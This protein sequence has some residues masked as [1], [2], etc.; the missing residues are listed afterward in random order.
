M[1]DPA[2]SP[3]HAVDSRALARTAA[4]AADAIRSRWTEVPRVGL[5]LGTGQGHLAEELDTVVSL[6]YAELPHFPRATALSHRGHLLCGSW[7]GVPVIAL[8]GRCHLYEGYSPAQL[9][10]PVYTLHALGVS[11]LVLSNAAGGLNPRFAA[12]DVMVIED[13]VSLFLNSSLGQAVESPEDIARCPAAYCYD[14]ALQAQ[15]LAVARRENFA[16]YPG[17]YV[18]MLG[19]NYETRAEYRL[20]RRIGDAVGMSTVPEAIAAAR[21]GLRTLGLSIITN[22]ARPDHPDVVRAE[23]VVAAAEAAEPKVRKIAAAV[24]GQRA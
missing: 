13:H 22:V 2:F 18:A 21:C 3:L 16:A 20:L 24:I 4:E 15:A 10:L 11:R 17:V 1:S 12:G 5:I 19:P 23:A 14:P 7:Q 9:M 8:E 6:P